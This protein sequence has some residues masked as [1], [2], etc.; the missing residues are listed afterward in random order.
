[1]INQ[2]DNDSWALIMDAVGHA[3]L[4]EYAASLGVDYIPENNTLTPAEMARIL[5][6]LYT[7]ALLEPADTARLLADMQDTNYETLIPAAVPAG[8]TVF[9]K[10]GLLGGELH[11]AGILARDGHAYA[12]VVYTK[13]EDLGS[14]PERT[15]VI[16]QITAVV[17]DALF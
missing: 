14:V 15:D 3:E 4:T 7:G 1:M 16:H 8:V 10:Y 12:F 2:S 5:A 9:H 17:A 11:D 13:G 6:G